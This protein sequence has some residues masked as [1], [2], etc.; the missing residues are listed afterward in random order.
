MCFL[1]V[2]LLELRRLVF[3]FSGCNSVPERTECRC[4]FTTI[5]KRSG[6]PYFAQWTTVNFEY[7]VLFS[8][9]FLLFY[10]PRFLLVLRWLL[11]IVSLHFLETFRFTWDQFSVT[12][13][14]YGNVSS[15]T[16]VCIKGA[17]V[18]ISCFN[19]FELGFPCATVSVSIRK[20]LL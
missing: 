18:S 6:R 10:C 5:L 2:L 20:C 3:G 8:L 12:R 9:I 1:C 14:L 13:L 17:I 19:L 11:I 7:Q 4:W 16:R 15:K